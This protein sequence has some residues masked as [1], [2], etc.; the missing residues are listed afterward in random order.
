V[1]DKRDP[2]IRPALAPSSSSRAGCG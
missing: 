1:S 2:P